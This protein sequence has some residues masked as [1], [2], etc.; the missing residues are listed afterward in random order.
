[1]RGLPSHPCF[2]NRQ[3]YSIG[4]VMVEE[5]ENVTWTQHSCP[6]SACLWTQCDLLPPCSPYCEGLGSRTMNQNKPILPENIFTLTSFEGGEAVWKSSYA[7]ISGQSEQLVLPFHC[8]IRGLNSAHQPWWKAFLLG[9]VSPL[10]LHL[11][12]IFCFVVVLCRAWARGTYAM[13]REQIMGADPL[14]SPRGFQE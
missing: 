2:L 11:A 6:S 7:E 9:D 12:F 1:M 13:V 8:G 10:P 5:N 4:W 3:Q 14:L